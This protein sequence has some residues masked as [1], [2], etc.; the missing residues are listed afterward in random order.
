MEVKFLTLDSADG[1]RTFKQHAYKAYQRKKYYEN[2]PYKGNKQLCNKGGVYNEFDRYEDF[3]ELYSEIVDVDN[4]C[5][6]CLKI[7]GK[8]LTKDKTK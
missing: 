7:Y 1:E 4:C 2:E 3:D 6:T 8:S 5:K